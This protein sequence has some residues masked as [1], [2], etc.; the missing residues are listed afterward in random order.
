MII[1]MGVIAFPGFGV[2]GLSALPSPLLRLQADGTP[3]AL[4]CTSTQTASATYCDVQIVLMIDDS[5]S[6]RT[7]DPQFRNPA[8]GLRNQGAKNLVDV[9]ATQFYLPAVQLRAD[10]PEVR[11]P[12]VRVA[13]IHFSETLKEYSREW[14]QINPASLEDWEKQRVDLYKLIDWKNTYDTKQYTHFIEPF[15]KAA[16]LFKSGDAQIQAGDCVRRSIM[17]FT[18]GTPEDVTGILQGKPLEEEMNKVNAIVQDNLSGLDVR[19]YVTGFKISPKY[20]VNVE[21][22]WSKIVGPQAQGETVA[23]SVLLEGEDSLIQMASRMEEITASLVNIQSLV[24]IPDTQAPQSFSVEVPKHTQSLRLTLYNLD[25]QAGLLITNPDGNQL[26][27]DGQN[28]ILSG[29]TTSVEVWQLTGP[30]AGTYKVQMSKRNGILTGLLT[31]QNL[32]VQ[33]A[34]EPARLKESVA[35][36]LK[37]KLLDSSGSV[38]LPGDD[39]AY[40]LDLKVLVTQAA[41]EEALPWTQDA[42]DYQVSWTPKASGD[43]RFTVEADL[44]SAEGNVLWHCAGDAATL[45]VDPASPTP[46]PPPGPPALIITPPAACVPPGE[47]IVLPIQLKY[48]GDRGWASTLQWDVSAAAQ[49]GGQ[50]VNAKVTAVNAG[51][52]DY[53]L[54]IDPVSAQ[55]IRLN[56]SAKAEI[57]GQPVDISGG[58]TLTIQ[59]CPSA[60]ACDQS[61]T[62]WFWFLAILLVGLL[63][64]LLVLKFRRG[65]EDSGEQEKRDRSR[66]P[67]WHLLF[68][69]L[70]ILLILLILNRLF[71]CCVIPPWLFLALIFILLI[72][73]LPLWL[74][75]EDEPARRRPW[76]LLLILLLGLVLI[77]YL[78]TAGTW[79]Y[80][81]WL[82]VLLLILVWVIRWSRAREKPLPSLWLMVLAIFILSIWIVL[83]AGLPF[84]LILIWLLIWLV[85][86]LLGWVIWRDPEWRRSSRFWLLVILGLA[87]AVVWFVLF[88]GY[89]T[90]LFWLL[91]LGI[92]IIR[93]MTRSRE[94]QET[95]F[96]WWLLILA[97]LAATIGFIF[98]GKFPFWL[99]LLLLLMWLVILFLVWI[100]FREIARRSTFQPWL[101][102]VAFII[103]AV[104]ALLYFGGYWIFLLLWLLVLLVLILIILWLIPSAPAPSEERVLP[105]PPDEK[106]IPVPAG[107]KDD[108][109]LVEGIGPRVEQLLNENGIYTFRQLVNADLAELNRWLNENRLQYMDPKTWPHQAALADKAKTSGRKED[110]DEFYKYLAS[111]KGGIAPGEYNKSEKDRKPPEEP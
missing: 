37:F 106:V 65:R 10:N 27:P 82:L 81:L 67:Y 101:A 45:P 88:R 76:W 105:A 39:P 91:L 98:L 68:W 66:A 18:D 35:S 44:T 83:A 41:Q 32:A 28:V 87:A 80:L 7:N 94:Q 3:Q 34:P 73:L 43:A 102:L 56:V 26:A 59:I 54:S 107:E 6:M 85:I 46:E 29:E 64:I 9:L 40:T 42:Q 84:W 1:M 63:L 16:E 51:S 72:V 36:D 31:Y 11:L 111:V 110:W 17:L 14:I 58:Q 53:R 103:L 78:F 77:W 13:V 4:A 2:Q 50:S 75:R 79:I 24:L 12:D 74:S 33:F 69:P 86:T 61:W 25:P 22:Y 38:V 52:G 8:G 48:D 100:F 109:K 108:L 104:L 5:G 15:A 23:R 60:C 49:P 21:P 70:L 92:L 71:W 62:F 99:I 20:W 19:V 55:E 93:Y 57:A 97:T 95:D 96:S 47:T 30:A 90:A 89:W